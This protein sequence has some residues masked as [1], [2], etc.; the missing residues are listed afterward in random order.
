[1]LG[2]A[3]T[4]EA[5]PRPAV[6]AKDRRGHR[7]IIIAVAVSVLGVLGLV[8][9]FLLGQAA[10]REKDQ[11]I[12]SLSTQ[13]DQLYGDAKALQRQVEDS[14]QT[15]VV[16]PSPITVE[17]PAGA[18]GPAGADG[19]P[20]APGPAGSPGTNGV[21]PACLSD[22]SQCRG[23]DGTP[24]KDGADGAPGQPGADGAPGAPGADGRPPA[25]FSFQFAGTNYLCTRDGAS[26]DTAAT[27]SC[28]PAP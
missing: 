26:P 5:L 27:Y 17:G 22:S 19:T 11:T 14:G 24:G 15:P 2:W 3:M 12:S 21:T 28:N 4:A 20:G 13:G 1:M 25:S 23:A 10:G 9:A 6:R 16:Q 18:T 8:G 7:W